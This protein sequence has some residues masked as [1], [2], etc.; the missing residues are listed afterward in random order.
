MRFLLALLVVASS[1]AAFAKPPR[2]LPDGQHPEDHRLAE[3]RNLNSYFPFQQVSAPHDWPQRQAEI[4]RR[5]LV[6]QGLWPLPSKSD[7]NAV[8][9]GRVERDDY[10][11]DR[12][13]FESIPGHYV[14]G[15]LYR[16]RGQDGPF[17][18]ILS[19]HGHWAN[20]RFYDAG[21]AHVQG[22][23]QSGAEQDQIGGRY[24]IQARAVQLARWV[25]WSLFTI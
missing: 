15:S 24:P 25:V 10:L 4:K 21:E 18:A 3:L 20:G 19:P 6:S 11:V 17:P 16:P 9:H 8:I 13:F 22:D 1:A 23:L 14:T 2:A 7:L 5:I 12:V